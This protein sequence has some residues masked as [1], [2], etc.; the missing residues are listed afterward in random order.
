MRRLFYLLGVV[1]IVLTGCTLTSDEPEV[2]YVTATPPQAAA[3][4]QQVPTQPPATVQTRPT[5]VLSPLPEQV[6]VPT[7]NM[8]RSYVDVDAASVHTVQAGDTLTGIALTYGT[9]VDTLL[10]FNEFED[11]NALFVG[12]QV[13]LPPRPTEE[14]SDLKLLPN[15]LLVR[16]PGSAAFDIA[17]FIN[18]QPG[19]IRTVTDLVDTRQADGSIEESRLNAAQIIERISLEFSV[20]PRV[21]LALLE[22][23]ARWLTEPNVPEEVGNYPLISEEDS[24]GVDR[25]GLYRQLAWTA[26]QLNA[27]YYGWKYREWIMVAFSPEERL[28]INPNLNA[29]TVALQHFLSLN[30]TQGAWVRDVSRNGFYGVYFNY[31]G[32]PFISPFEPVVPSNLQQPEMTLPFIPNQ[33]WFYTGGWHGG[34]GSGSAW[35]AVDFAPPDDPADTGGVSCY[36]SSYFTTAVAPGLIVRS[37]NGV[38]VLDLDGDG[39]ESTGWTVLYLHLA[40]EDRIAAG[41]RVQA[42]DRIGRPACEGG[43]STATHLHLARRYNGE[44]LPADCTYC[45]SEY[46]PPPFTMS[47]W[48]VYG[49]QGQEYQGFMQN[50]VGERRIAEQGRLTPDNRVSW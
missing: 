26:N 38:V 43:F 4:P 44:W 45:I 9:D 2:I 34:W 47:G 40:A 37:E 17:A 11:P 8:P 19:Y 41:T 12:Q 22:Y 30:N 1:F 31:F 7:A 39:D 28:L 25:E 15:S 5:V 21:L 33:T 13:S 20:D 3:P 29:G 10:A 27:G 48:T 42:G 6:M 18:T 35:A 50:V 14:T 36:T 24:E 23:R 16:A 46:N 49:L 32:D